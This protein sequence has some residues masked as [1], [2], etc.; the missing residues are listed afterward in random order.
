MGL[1]DNWFNKANTMHYAG[2][3][4]KAEKQQR[5]TVRTNNQQAAKNRGKNPPAGSGNNGRR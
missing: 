4:T 3:L 1:M 2:G 5:R